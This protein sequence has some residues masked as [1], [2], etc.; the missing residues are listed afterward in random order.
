METIQ[1]HLKKTNKHSKTGILVKLRKNMAKNSLKT[2]NYIKK[3]ICVN[4]WIE[5]T[6]CYLKSTVNTWKHLQPFHFFT[7]NVSIYFRKKDDSYF[8]TGSGS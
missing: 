1:L 5:I 7:V 4:V 2:R 8:R 6:P 3:K